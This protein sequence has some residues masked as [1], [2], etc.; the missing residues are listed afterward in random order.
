MSRIFIS[1]RREDSSYPADR[2]FKG[3]A[4]YFG[5][6]NVFKDIDTIPYGAD[7][8]KV[9][10]AKVSSCDALIAV[11][12]KD[13]LNAKDANG[14]RRLDNARDWV[15]N[16]IATALKRDVL[17]IPFLLDDVVM[18][19][20]RDL[21]EDLARL[22]KRQK[23]Q[24]SIGHFDRDVDR[25]IRSLC[26]E[27]QDIAA[28]GTEL[29]DAASEPPRGTSPDDVMKIEKN[30]ATADAP[31]ADAASLAPATGPDIAKI[32]VGEERIFSDHAKPVTTMAFSP[33]SEVLASAGGGIWLGGGDNVVRLWRLADG[34]LLHRL[35]GHR[36]TVNKV[37]FS[38]CGEFLASCCS[39]ATLIWQLSNRK[40]VR[41][42]DRGA[43]LLAF[44]DDGARLIALARRFPANRKELWEGSPYLYQIWSMPDGDEIDSGTLDDHREVPGFRWDNLSRDGRLGVDLEDVRIAQK[45]YR[46][47][48]IRRRS[49]ATMIREIPLDGD[50]TINAAVFSSDGRLI[51]GLPVLANP[52]ILWRVADGKLL[53]KIPW[54]QK[55]GSTD[56]LRSVAIAPDSSWLA[57]SSDLY[58]KIRVWPLTPSFESQVDS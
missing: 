31:A 57:A 56:W 26:R 5:A 43:Q 17:V 27:L 18:P 52:I 45:A 25:L 44:S 34:R 28:H 55:A 19:E 11:I 10:E 32:T 47:V 48:V 4:G 58:N 49:D 3:L 9:I 7:F 24:T 13:W 1:Y 16:E 23:L 22:A 21:P 41:T 46:A 6:D 35:E 37:A 40:C 15:R 42:L 8:E 39:K 30:G 38:P 51:V 33:N 20:P 2:L 36:R 54:N 53:A 12:G 14:N 50:D 29:S